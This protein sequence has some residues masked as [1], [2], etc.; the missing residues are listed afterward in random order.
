MVSRDP[1][2]HRVVL[3]VA[4]LGHLA[5]GVVVAASGLIMPG[6][7]VAVLAVVWALG[8]SAMLRW[9]AHAWRPLAVPVLVLAVWAAVAS[10]GD[11]WLGWTA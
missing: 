3:V 6:W 8:A 9:R 10:A 2:L 7:A 11:A 1:V 4:A 5:V